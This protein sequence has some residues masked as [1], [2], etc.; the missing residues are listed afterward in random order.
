MKYLIF[1]LLLGVF[2]VLRA[3]GTPLVEVVSGVKYWVHFVQS[4]NTLYGIHKSYNVPLDQIITANPGC[5][6]GLVEGQKLLIPVSL[7]EVKHTVVA[8]ETLF[9]ISKKYGVKVEAIL[10]D[11]PGAELGL[12]VGQVLVIK[13]VMKDVVFEDVNN[14]TEVTIADVDTIRFQDN[15]NLQMSFS[16]SIID[17]TVLAHE[18]LYI[19][20]K[21]YMVSTAELQRFNGLK[22]TKI[23][24]GDRL[25]IP[26]KK[27]KVEPVLIRPVTQKEVRLVEENIVYP[28]KS[29]YN[30]A[31]LLPL[32]LD[33]AAGYPDQLATFA[34]E[35]Y[36]GA[37]LALDSLESLGLNAN[38]YVFDVKIDSASVKNILGKDE[39]LDMDMVIGPFSME[40]AT[41]V[42]R[43]C[44]ENEVRMVCPISLPTA[45][46]QD[47]RFVVQSVPSE[48][49]QLSELALFAL[50][51]RKAEQFILIKPNGEKDQV[52]YASFRNAFTT[53][54]YNGSRPKLIDATLENF[55]T[56]LR[57]GVQTV[58]IFPTSDKLQ[59]LR[60]MNALNA[61]KS[62]AQF[63]E[64][65]GS[66]EWL[67]F[68]EMKASFR[69]RFHF[70]FASPNDL[71][72]TYEKTER[73]LR[74]YRT[75]Y[76][77]DLSKMAAQG[78]DVTYYFIA[79]QL[80]G[81]EA[82]EMLMNAFNLVQ[83]GTGNGVENGTVFI[84]RQEDYKLIR[85]N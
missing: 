65:Y 17:H 3:Q 57:K 28:S 13:G 62:D 71:N 6:K 31:L 63:I 51:N 48:A 2:T 81:I 50:K 25:R 35:F 67:N 68:D 10:A 32:F 69:N 19:I 24:P 38:V 7:V 37:K 9:A 72:F 60:F 39:F 55:T 61:S 12:K 11:N 85:S 22:N 8:K 64:V 56:F 79:S 23:K 18:N 78:F 80:M 76:N 70:H 54:P 1:T 52:A 42:A 66:R 29:K 75:T 73:F 4:G 36:M 21:R 82:K 84:I 83:K 40:S 14:F 49:T 45:L 26:V 43:W 58:L 77:A 5:E 20:S 59:T 33:R 16:D 53:S 41:V 47:N 27:E 30:I 44:K 15:P 46:I 74:K 34:T